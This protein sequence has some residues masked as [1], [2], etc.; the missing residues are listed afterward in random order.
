[1]RANERHTAT[2]TV[3]GI[4][5]ITSNMCTVCFLKWLSSM[6]SVCSGSSGDV[7][8]ISAISYTLMPRPILLNNLDILAN[9]ETRRECLATP[10]ACRKRLPKLS[11]HLVSVM[12]TECS[13]ATLYT[14]IRVGAAR[15][16]CSEKPPDSL[17]TISGNRTC[18]V[19]D[20]IC[21]G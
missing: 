4:G 17:E 16:V 12:S 18:T 10:N 14:G 15:R 9:G 2:W 19:S 3:D 1:M 7:F 8:A 11:F 5:Y 6:S 20:D 21:K 13:S